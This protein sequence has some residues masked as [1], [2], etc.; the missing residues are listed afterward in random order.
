[1]ASYDIMQHEV[2]QN[3]KVDQPHDGLAQ[4]EVVQKYERMK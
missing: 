1:M 4:E 2:C 3:G